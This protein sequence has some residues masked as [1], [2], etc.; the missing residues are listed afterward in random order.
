MKAEDY[1]VGFHR[2]RFLVSAMRWDSFV[3][4]FPRSTL[5]PM[6]PGH[7]EE[8]RESF[9]FIEHRLREEQGLLSAFDKAPVQ[10][11]TMYVPRT[12]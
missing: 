5:L 8:V 10:R 2:K 6:A 11:P 3:F 12:K 9:R 1:L 7:L 4:L